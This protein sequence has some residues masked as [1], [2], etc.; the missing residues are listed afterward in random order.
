MFGGYVGQTRDKKRLEELREQLKND[1][2]NKAL[3]DKVKRQE[4]ENNRKM[5]DAI[6]AYSRI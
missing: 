2:D 6:T 4:K 1:P 5:D 3:Q